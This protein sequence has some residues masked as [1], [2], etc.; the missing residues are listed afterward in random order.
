MPSAC[1]QPG[2]GALCMAPHQC[3]LLLD[4]E[5][6]RRA[7]T[8]RLLNAPWPSQGLGPGSY[9][10]D[11]AH[12]RGLRHQKRDWCS[13][14]FLLPLPHTTWSQPG[15]PPSCLNHEYHLSP[16]PS[17]NPGLS[18]PWPSLAPTRLARPGPGRPR[19]TYSAGWSWG[20]ARLRCRRSRGCGRRRCRSTRFL[21]G[22]TGER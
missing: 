20:S 6:G 10:K 2:A 3:L 22:H 14:V 19:G 12:G 13:E 11:R 15:T 5:P 17:S 8:L 1:C 9:S 16:R 18:R 7:S 21:L 4:C